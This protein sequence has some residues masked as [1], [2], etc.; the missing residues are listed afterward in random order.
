[1]EDFEVRQALAIIKDRVQEIKKD[2]D[3]KQ[4][5]AKE[6]NEA[7][8]DEPG[9]PAED[10]QENIYNLKKQAKEDDQKS[11][12]SYSK[13]FRPNIIQRAIEQEFQK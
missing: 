4:K 2:D 9:V 10:Y 7:G 1:M 3:W 8:A 11:H 5:I 6:W 13:K 12:V